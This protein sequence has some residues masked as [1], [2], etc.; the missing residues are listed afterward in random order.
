MTAGRT[1]HTAFASAP[2][3]LAPEAE[4]DCRDCHHCA[5]DPDGL[6]CGH[7]TSMKQG[8]PWGWGIRKAR[9]NGFPC[10]PSGALFKR[11][12]ILVLNARGRG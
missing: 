4:K 10:G 1:N 7:Q 2:F 12:P 9:D 5:N 3:V 8:A 11:A 6:F